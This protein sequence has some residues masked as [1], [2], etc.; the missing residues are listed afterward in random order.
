M[1]CLIAC[2]YSGRMRE[3]FRA[4]GHEVWSIDLLPSEDDSP[5]HLIGDAL[6][7]AYSG[8]YDL[9]IAHPPCTYLANS[10]VRWL[11]DNPPRQQKM[12]EAA[13]FFADLARAPIDMIAIENPIMHY[14]GRSAIESLIGRPLAMRFV[15]PWWFGDEAFKATGFSLKNL[16]AL[17]KPSTALEPPEYGTD[18][19]KRWSAIH[20]ASPK[21]DRWKERSRTFPGIAKACAEAWG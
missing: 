12:R 8:K 6:E 7:E 14:S 3:A 10:G 9:M 5:Y 2:E 18:D 20:R 4:K 21:K 11:V 19:Y 17:Q 1:R 15:Q 13:K 16:P